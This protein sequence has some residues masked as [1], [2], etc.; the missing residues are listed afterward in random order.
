MQA[1]ITGG[2]IKYGETRKMAD[3]ENKRADVEL[4]FNVPEGQEHEDVINHV[5][6]LAYRHCAEMLGQSLN[7]MCATE[8][9]E[10][11]REAQEKLN[12][13]PPK[14]HSKRA[15]KMPVPEHLESAAIVAAK[16][17]VSKPIDPVALEEPEPIKPVV[18]EALATENSITDADLMDA[19]S[20]HQQHVKNAPAIRKL[21][22]ELG[23]KTP[24]G[25][26]ID[27]PQEKRQDYLIRLS[28]IQ[29]LA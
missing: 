12:A 1:Q 2:S 13:G 28:Q 21:L 9:V 10:R 18:K 11:A 24:P 23:V 20:K 4:A 29:P 5:K 6:G 19:T 15:P 27:L 25:R 17:E 14:V 3:Y 8:I 22:N 26:L 16:S 7:N